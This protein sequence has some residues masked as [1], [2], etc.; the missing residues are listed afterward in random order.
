MR[1]RRTGRTPTLNTST[2][3]TPTLTV[4]RS[5]PPAD[6]R[7]L[8]ARLGADPLQ[9]QGPGGNTSIKTPVGARRA[10]WIK[11][12]G[13]EL[14]D[15]EARDVFV[16]VDVARARAEIDG[17]PGTD[18]TCRAA[19]LDAASTIRPSIRPSIETTFH[20][21]LDAA[22]VLHTHSVATLAHAVGAMGTAAAMA[23]LEGMNA[24]AVPYAKPG[25]PLTRA[26][27]AA[28]TPE[29][30]VFVLRNH[31]LVVAGDDVADAAARIAQVE[32]RL[33]LPARDVTDGEAF[34]APP[35]WETVPWAASLAH[36]PRATA[37]TLY[38]DHAVFLGPGL[39]IAPDRIDPSQW[40]AVLPGRG[41]MLR[42]GAGATRRAMLRCLV[43][44][45]ARVPP[46]WGVEPIGAE[47]EAELMNW[48]AETYRKAFA[49]KAALPADGGV[50]PLAPL[51]GE[52]S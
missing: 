45:L 35:G 4:L 40:T 42:E 52:G 43:D 38:P 5:G 28:A 37:G 10:M 23:K 49:S 51:P 3:S 22:V 36:N 16:A 11:A 12:S 30:R 8:S 46:E 17:V 26:I 25:L 7:A 47:A 24:V 19:M 15:A 33:A 13:T 31:G 39:G 50:R 14:A 6:F 48:D 34:D 18:G 27:R 9:I 21:A 1:D 41:A 32:R 20:A 29:T 44:V 2:P